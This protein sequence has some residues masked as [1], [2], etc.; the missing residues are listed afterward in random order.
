MGIGYSWGSGTLTYQGQK[1]PLKFQGLSIVNVGASEYTATGV[2]Y[3][4]D[5]V[6]DISGNYV[7]GEA[8][9]TVAGGASVFAM[10]NENGVVIN[11]TATRA[12]LQFT[13]APTGMKL[14]LA[15]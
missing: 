13:L 4:L 2:V 8:G 9:A 11:M 10:K 7:A 14:T 12:G 15:S 6:S 1:Y 3:H 5:K